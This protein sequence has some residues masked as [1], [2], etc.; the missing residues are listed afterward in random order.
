MSDHDGNTSNPYRP[1]PEK[2][3][4][5]CVFGSGKHGDWCVLPLPG[6]IASDCEYC[7]PEE[8]GDFEAVGMLAGRAICARCLRRR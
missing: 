2:C 4:E 5:A 8:C 3:C 6:G 1:N 7:V